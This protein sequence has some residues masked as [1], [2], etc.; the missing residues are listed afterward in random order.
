MET[1]KSKIK[2]PKVCAPGGLRLKEMRFLF[3][4]LRGRE[5]VGEM[6]TTAAGKEKVVTGFGW[7]HD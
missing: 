5:G 1:A 7:A 6:L 3:Q 2:F 4:R